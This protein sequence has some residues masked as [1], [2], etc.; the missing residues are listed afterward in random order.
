MF[1][2]D[3][4][5]AASFFQRV[6]QPRHRVEGLLIKDCAGK[7]YYFG[8]SDRLRHSYDIE[9]VAKNI[10]Q[11]I[12]RD[13]FEWFQWYSGGAQMRKRLLNSKLNSHGY[14]VGRLLFRFFDCPFSN[15]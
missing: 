14:F 4:V 8:C 7:G 12:S 6:S 10:A 9:R 15:I 3:F 2:D 5:S 11:E 1:E 13:S